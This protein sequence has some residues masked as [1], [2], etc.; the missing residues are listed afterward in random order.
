M[1]ILRTE[2]DL[3]ARPAAGKVVQTS[4]QPAQPAQ[5]SQGGKPLPFE[6]PRVADAEATKSSVD[7]IN[8]QLETEQRSIRLVPDERTDFAVIRIVE[9]ESG[10]VIRQIPAEQ[11]LKLAS[12]WEDNGIAAGSEVRGLTVDEQA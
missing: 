8:R 2:Y 6:R 9:Q 4:P 11:V 3:I 10:E 1:D 7:A 12:W 5:E